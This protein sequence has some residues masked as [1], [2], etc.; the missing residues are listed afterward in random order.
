[1]KLCIVTS[2]WQQNINYWRDTEGSRAYTFL[3]HGGE[4]KVQSLNR[5]N[6]DCSSAGFALVQWSP[7]PF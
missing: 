7:V 3:F 2:K 1:M 4:K 6:V 5:N